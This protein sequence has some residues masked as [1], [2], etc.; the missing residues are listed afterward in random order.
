MIVVAIIVI[1]VAFSGCQSSRSFSAVGQFYTGYQSQLSQAENH[2]SASQTNSSSEH[3]MAA[4]KLLIDSNS[5]PF[6]KAHP[7]SAGSANVK[8]SSVMGNLLT[9]DL[10]PLR[11]NISHQGFTSETPI[12]LNGIIE[13]EHQKFA[14]ISVEAPEE[15]STLITAKLGSRI[16]TMLGD[17]YQVAAISK[18]SAIL[19]SENK[20]KP[21]TLRLF[22]ESSMILSGGKP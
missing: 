20:H 15:K 18:E 1:L 2:I 21:I 6:N 12:R 11:A 5:S 16:K 8:H 14:L 19:N 10:K 13:K 9:G 4:I 7:V 3:L 22:P 17:V